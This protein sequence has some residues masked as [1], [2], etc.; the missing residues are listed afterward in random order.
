MSDFSD[1]KTV[2][3]YPIF[4]GK[5]DY[6]KILRCVLEPEEVQVQGTETRSRRKWRP[7]LELSYWILLFPLEQGEDIG[8]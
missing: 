5:K 1:S 6:D 3:N 8:K 7:L 2:R 4:Q